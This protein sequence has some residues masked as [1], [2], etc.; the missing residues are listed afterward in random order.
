[1]PGHGESG[2]YYELI[3]AKGMIVNLVIEPA[4]PEGLRALVPLD[5]APGMYWLR[6][7]GSGAV[8]ITTIVVE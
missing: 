3:D 1:V 5:L 8:S 4:S 7:A 6:G 2:L